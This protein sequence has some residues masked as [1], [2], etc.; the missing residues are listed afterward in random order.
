MAR[1]AEQGG[2]RHQMAGMAAAAGVGAGSVL[3]GG[4]MQ[5]LQGAWHAAP[6]EHQNIGNLML[7]GFQQHGMNGLA[8]RVHLVC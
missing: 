5:A 3:Q 1:L 4:G 6:Q 7:G 2:V 8:V